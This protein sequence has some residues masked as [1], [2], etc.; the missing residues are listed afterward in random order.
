M[1]EPMDAGN[2]VV[3]I[4]TAVVATAFVA[5]IMYMI[6]HGGK[7]KRER[8]ETIRRLADK[9]VELTPAIIENISRE[10]ASNKADFRRGVLL[11]GL[12]AAIIAF[13]ALLGETE[14]IRPWIGIAMFPG[15]I[16]IIYSVFGIFK[17]K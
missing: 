11:M 9:G 8:Q 5:P 17:L 1:A 16:G 4:N 7:I 10:P 13:G 15:I 6:W 12:G 14:T 3:M 2:I